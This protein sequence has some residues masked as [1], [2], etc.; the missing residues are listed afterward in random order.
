MALTSAR[1][2]ELLKPASFGFI[3]L[4]L[5]G[6]LLLNLLPWQGL[7]LSFRPDFVALVLLF[8]AIHEPR[9]LGIGLPWLAG[10]LMDIGDGAILGQHAFAYILAVYAAIV[11][12]RRIQTFGL[13]QQASHVLVL[14]LLAQAAMLLI[15][16]FGGAAAPGL[17]YFLA[18]LT[19]AALWPPLSLLLLLPQRGRPDPNTVY[20]AGHK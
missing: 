4:T 20:S 10:L 16:L 1:A 3:L 7:V 14:L 17:G 11:L 12:H 13:W 5:A 18:C 9:K 6:A 2:P 15:R 19:G 8:W